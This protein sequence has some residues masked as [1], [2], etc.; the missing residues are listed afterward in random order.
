MKDIA[1]KL[2]IH[3][4]TVTAMK[5]GRM[6]IAPYAARIAEIL[7]VPQEW[8]EHGTG[9]A[10]AW[11]TQ[12]DSILPTPPNQNQI[13]LEI[14]KTQNQI[15]KTLENLAKRTEQNERLL[16]HLAHPPPPTL[17]LGPHPQTKTG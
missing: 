14:L 4:N 17:D 12:P 3:K 5:M 7:N 1:V 16:H 11:F 2:G 10:P 6:R 13:L 8:L 9:P 15:A